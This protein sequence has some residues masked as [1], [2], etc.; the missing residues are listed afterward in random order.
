VFD[1]GAV[2]FRQ[3]ILEQTVECRRDSPPRSRGFRN[4]LLTK[5]DPDVNQL[6]KVEAFQ[7]T[8]ES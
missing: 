7:G 4:A 6:E 1:F 5:R 8:P 3:R 2:L